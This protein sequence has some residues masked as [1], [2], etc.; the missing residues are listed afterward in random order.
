M[1]AG[2]ASA[3]GTPS[4]RPPHSRPN[5]VSQPGETTDR[6]AP[7][8]SMSLAMPAS[9]EASRSMDSSFA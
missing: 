3:T 8:G 7:A 6:P 5:W 4:E 9:T 2:L 1:S